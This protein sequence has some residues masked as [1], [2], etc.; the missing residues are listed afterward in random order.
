MGWEYS[1]LSCVEQNDTKIRDEI[2]KF[3][4]KN[5]KPYVCAVSIDRRCDVYA[6]PSRTLTVS[7]TA[8]L[9]PSMS[10]STQYMIYISYII[11]I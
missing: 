1:T 5:S 8:T 4:E 2:A 9:A 7:T 6:K 11:S 10:L 3:V